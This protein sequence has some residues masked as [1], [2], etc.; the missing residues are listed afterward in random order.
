[1]AFKE[2]TGAKESKSRVRIRERNASW[3]TKFRLN[4]NGGN[5]LKFEMLKGRKWEVD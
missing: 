3:E 2:T 4:D 1:M 5:Q